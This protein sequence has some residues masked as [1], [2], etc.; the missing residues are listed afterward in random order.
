MVDEEAQR[1]LA[2]LLERDE[3]ELGIELLKLLL[4]VILKVLHR[5]KT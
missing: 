2:G 3:V 4:D 1:F 5:L